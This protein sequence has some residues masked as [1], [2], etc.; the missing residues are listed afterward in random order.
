MRMREKTLIAIIAIF[1]VLI[2]IEFFA[3]NLIVMNSFTGLETNETLQSVSQANSAY[4]KELDSMDMLLQ[5]WA[6]RDDSYRYM[7]HPQ[8]DYIERNMQDQA[9]IAQDLNLLLMVNPSGDI[10]YGKA[11]DLKNQTAVFISDDIKAQIDKDSPLMMRSDFDRMS[12]VLV[13][14]EGPMLVVARPI[15]NS[16]KQGPSLGTMIMGRYIDENLTRT[17]AGTTHLNLMI[18]NLNAPD[19]PADVQEARNRSE[20]SGSTQIVIPLDDDYIGGYKVIPDVSGKSTLVLR[21]EAPRLIYQKGRDTISYIILS[22]LIVGVVIAAIA[23][24]LL[25]RIVLSRLS[26]LD[27]AV[28]RISSGDDLSAR[29][30]VIGRDEIASLSRAINGML[31]WL[32]MSSRELQESESRYHAIVEDQSELICRFKPDGTLD[33]SNEAYRR[34]FGTEGQPAQEQNFIQTLPPVTRKGVEDTIRSLSREEPAKIVEC[35]FDINGKTLWLQW[36]IRAVFGPQGQV[37]ELQAVGRDITELIED[38]EQI[39]ASLREKEALLKE[40]HHRVKNNLQIISSILSLQE[41]KVTDKASREMLRDSRNR[42]KTMALI[43]EKLYGSYDL[44]SINMDEYIKGLLKN[45]LSSYGNNKVHT[46]TDCEDISLNID[47]AI[48][49]GLI[50]NELL[51]N[52]FKYAFPGDKGGEIFVELHAAGPGKYVLTVGDTGVGIPENIDVRHSNSLGL[53]LVNALVEQTKSSL[54]V[55][56]NNG[57]VFKITFSA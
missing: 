36:N 39:K 5:S 40:I 17:L 18:F 35:R 44:S 14:P 29:V 16:S 24:V 23:M 57:T 43:H 33:F 7:I 42:I 12:G 45:L 11:F 25:D 54:V 19:L 1:A 48:P 21:V 26:N 20:S 56:R 47:T 6:M 34:Y 2:L 4:H 52:S 15:L 3:S 31:D 28:K 27:A 13:L 51:T 22:T 55:E 46:R 37:V 10:V 32:N 30:P 41:I 49:L 8:A 9:F 38:E 53:E 50:I